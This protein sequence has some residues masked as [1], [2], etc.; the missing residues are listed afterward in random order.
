MCN[1]NQI[2]MIYDLE[3]SGLD[4][5]RNAIMQISACM[6]EMNQTKGIVPLE[7]IDLKIRPRDGKRI[8]SKTLE[9][10][11]ISEADLM[12]RQTDIEAFEKFVA[13]INRHN[14]RY[15]KHDKITL[16]GFGNSTFHTRFL[17][18]W[19]DDNCDNFFG[20][21]FR[22]EEIDIKSIAALSCVNK[23]PYLRSL[24]L[25]TVAGIYGIPFDKN[26]TYDSRY[27]LSVICKLF[28]KVTKTTG[29]LLP[30]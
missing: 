14:E 9:M 11:R 7:A 27:D 17:R 12:E 16:C 25:G 5:F 15:N 21:F 10:Q 18:N 24:D 2:V 4:P 26:K 22:P 1:L 8:D 3:T 6:V 28:G 23:R 19:F 30:A 13:F 29:L 20:A